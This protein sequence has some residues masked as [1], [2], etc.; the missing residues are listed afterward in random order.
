MWAGDTSGYDSHSEADSA[1][2]CKLAFWTG[3][4]RERMD[5]LFRQSGLM[6]AKW[7]EARG[8]RTYGERTIKNVLNVVTTTYN[9]NKMTTK[10]NRTYRN[11]PKKAGQNSEDT[12]GQQPEP[13]TINDV[14][15]IVVEEFDEQTWYATEAVLAAHATLLIAGSTGTGLALVGPSS[16]GKTTVLEFF[17]ELDDMVYRSDDVT[18]A[19]FVSH[20]ASKGDEELAEI[21]LI[22]KIKQ[23]TLLSRDMATWFAGDQEDI[24]KRMSVMTNLLDGKGYTRDTGTHGTRGYTGC[25]YRFNF[26]GATTPLK[27][28]AWH[29]MGNVGAR[30]VFYERSGETDESNVVADLIDGSNY[31]EKVARCREIVGGFLRKVWEDTGGYSSIEAVPPAGTGERDFLAY[32]I[33]VVRHARAVVDE[34]SI[35]TEG[36]HRIGATLRDIAQARAV[37]DGRREFTVEDMQVCAR[38]TLSTMPKAR[39]PLVQA[40][41]ASTAHEELIAAD[42]E[43]VAGVSRPTAHARMELLDTL[44]IGRYSEAAENGRETKT[45]TV[46]PKFEWPE[47]VPFPTF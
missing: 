17:E 31:H 9:P 30:L 10:Y 15:Q 23:K 14:R 13:L 2:C 41:L 20:D 22:P 39:R 38:L 27:P 11:Y 42:F 12:M 32:L 26:I 19:S 34:G 3:G 40:L 33:E 8:D 47:A 45:V 37:L 46:R 25:E 28:R 6:R 44:G 29:A 1:L 7:D 36:G 43:R 35:Q 18:P 24:Y 5:Q 4:D 16:S 21:D